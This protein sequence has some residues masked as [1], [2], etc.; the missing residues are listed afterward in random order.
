MVFR[1]IK[2]LSFTRRCCLVNRASK[3]LP[4]SEEDA[5]NRKYT[6]VPKNRQ[7][8]KVE[9]NFLLAEYDAMQRGCK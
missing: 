4:T 2:N 5:F 6:I 3:F 7:N 1:E 8:L 9:T